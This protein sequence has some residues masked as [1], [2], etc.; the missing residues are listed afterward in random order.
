MAFS[1]TDWL[2]LRRF[3]ERAQTAWGDV[4]RHFI[5]T[6][7]GTSIVYTQQSN[8]ATKETR[9]VHKDHLGSTTLEQAHVAAQ[10]TYYARIRY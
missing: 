5:Q 10:Q 2:I 8:S 6:P 7:G 4:F 1:D 3:A 9:Y